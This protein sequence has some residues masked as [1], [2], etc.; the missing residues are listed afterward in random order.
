TVGIE[1]ANYLRRGL[2]S[3]ITNPSSHF[4]KAKHILLFGTRCGNSDTHNRR[5]VRCSVHHFV[6]GLFWLLIRGKIDENVRRPRL[7]QTRVRNPMTPPMLLYRC[8][9]PMGYVRWR[10]KLPGGISEHFYRGERLCLNDPLRWS[11]RVCVR[12]NIELCLSTNYP[13]TSPS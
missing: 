9:C 12:M 10:G 11:V 7:V 4:V 8:A 1:T 6:F 2:C 5:G 3:D 13:D